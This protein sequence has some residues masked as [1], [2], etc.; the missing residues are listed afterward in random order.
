LFPFP[1]V[2]WVFFFFSFSLYWE[3]IS[4]LS[5][6][7][8]FCP[9]FFLGLTDGRILLWEPFFFV[10]STLQVSPFLFLFNTFSDEAFFSFLILV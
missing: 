5:E 1:Y 7:V 10:R 4:F 2:D 9:F 8:F 6:K 3:A